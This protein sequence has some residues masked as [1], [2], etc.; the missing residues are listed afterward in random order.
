MP[1]T[2]GGQ[3]LANMQDSGRFPLRLA[4]VIF[5]R[6]LSHYHLKRLSL[7]SGFIFNRPTFVMEK[8]TRFTV[9]NF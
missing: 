4:M 1:L 5:D 9:D 3:A 7:E 8:S 2:V 6:R